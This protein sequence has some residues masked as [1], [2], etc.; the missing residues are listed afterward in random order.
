VPTWNYTAVHASGPVE[1]FE[2]PDRLLEVV[3]WLTNLHEENRSHPWAVSDAPGA[4]ISGQLRGIVGLRMPIQKLEGK[5]KMS[6][7]RSLAD[8][9]GVRDGLAEST[10]IEDRIVASMIPDE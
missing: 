7:N 6:Q 1:F 4:F 5:C 9:I 10:D 8:R 2:E 3:N